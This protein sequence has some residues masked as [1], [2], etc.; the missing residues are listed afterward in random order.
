MYGFYL[1]NPMLTKHTF[2]NIIQS[3]LRIGGCFY[4]NKQFDN[5]KKH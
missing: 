4:V 2:I 1:N 3:I 5:D